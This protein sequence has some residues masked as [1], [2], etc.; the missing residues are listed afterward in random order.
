[1]RE[2]SLTLRGINEGSR[3]FTAM[4]IGFPLVCQPEALYIYNMLLSIL[5]VNQDNNFTFNANYGG[6]TLNFP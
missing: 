4:K 2:L 6:K 3:A 5:Q 1:M